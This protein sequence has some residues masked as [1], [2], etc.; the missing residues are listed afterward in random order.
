[1]PVGHG[2]LPQKLPLNVRE[3]TCAC[4]ITHGR[5]VHAAINLKTIGPAVFARGAGVRTPWAS[6]RAGWWVSKQEGRG[7]TREGAHVPGWF[8]RGRGRHQHPRKGAVA[9]G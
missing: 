4:G 2:V 6:S 7:A 3:W 1:M 5:A 8:R 9:P